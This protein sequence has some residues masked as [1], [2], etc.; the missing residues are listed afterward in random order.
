MS[1]ASLDFEESWFGQFLDNLREAANATNFDDLHWTSQVFVAM[2]AAFSPNLNSLPFMVD[3]PVDTNGVVIDSTWQKWLQHD[4]YTLVESYR[5][6]LLQLEEISFD[7]G[8]HDTWFLQASRNY[9][10]A[11]TAENIPH[12]FWTYFGDHSDGISDR[13][14]IVVLPFFSDILTDVESISNEIPVQYSL[15]Q[16]Y[17]NPF[18]PSTIIRF[19][20]PEESNISIVVLN[21]LG[22]EIT[23][24]LNENL[25]SGSYEVDF[26]AAGLPSGIYF[27]KIQAG[28]FVETKKMIL[29]K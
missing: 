16:N 8:T 15:S 6:N 25:T 3:F 24:L 5:D 28:S 1:T 11:L 13:V 22:E 21:T 17:P 27:Y 4:P 29:L 20:V 18:N 9:D 10:S 14:A 7:C 26:D 12:D 2:G 23:T 19:S